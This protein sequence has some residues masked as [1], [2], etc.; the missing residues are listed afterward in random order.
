[1]TESLAKMTH[2][3]VRS[4]FEK[5]NIALLPIG[6]TEQHGKHLPLGTD[7]LIAEALAQEVASKTGT[8]LF[9]AIPYGVSKHHRHFPTVW[10]SSQLFRELVTQVALSFKPY[11]LRKLVLVNGH[12][13]NT[14][15]LGEVAGD[16]SDED[17]HCVVWEWWKTKVIED[18]LQ[19]EAGLD[20]GT[21]THAD[22]GETSMALAHFEEWVQMDRAEDH[23]TTIWAPRIHGAM[24]HF[25]THDFT[26]SGNLGAPTKASRELGDDLRALAIQELEL[27][28][29]W[30]DAY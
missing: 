19:K 28:L 30:L 23:P 5:R 1:M 3:D 26:E 10:I 13:G 17:I 9:P 21:V 20:L 27:A 4:Y 7:H 18:Y 25:F 8:L 14:M 2:I 22:L 11:G 12:G 6:S 29:A 16:L 15:A 24:V